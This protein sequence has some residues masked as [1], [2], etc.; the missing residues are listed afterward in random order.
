MQIWFDHGL[1]DY[2]HFAHLLQLYRHRGYGIRVHFEENKSLIWRAAG[3]EY[4]DLD[5]SPHH[6]WIY[7]EGFNWPNV[8]EEWSG[9][10][11]AGNINLPPLPYLV[12][13]TAAWKELCAVDLGGSVEDHLSA[14]VRE[15]ARRFLGDL[16]RPVVLLHTSGTNL[17]NAKNLPPNIV[18]E[19]Y[20]KLLDGFGGSLVLLDW[21][22]RVPTLAHGRV[23]H[24]K[25]DWGHLS[26]EQ[27]AAVMSE[28]SLFVALNL[29]QKGG[30]VYLCAQH[31]RARESS[32]GRRPGAIVLFSLFFLAFRRCW[33]GQLGGVES[34]HPRAKKLPGCPRAVA[35]L[36]NR[37]WRDRRRR[38]HPLDLLVEGALIGRRRRAGAFVDRGR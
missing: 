32:A 14:E 8:Q 1:G 26:L 13:I 12:E 15:A 24:L 9:N 33:C 35:R 30:R 11:I 22:S 38:R 10:K 20:R 3:V 25:R 16:L 18:T 36:A 2:V 34:G 17:P 5:G 37:D 31:L 7:R 19:F 21:D 23:R 6:D 29:L 4:S 27:L 28:C